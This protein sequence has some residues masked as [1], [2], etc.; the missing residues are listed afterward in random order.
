MKQHEKIGFILIF[1]FLFLNFTFSQSISPIYFQFVNSN[2]SSTVSFLQKIKILPEYQN[3]LEM[4]NNIYGDSVKGEIFAQENNKKGII[5]NLEQQLTINPKAR[6]VLYSLYQ[7]YL[8]EGD[9]NQA[10]N[11]LRQAKEVDPDLR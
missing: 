7:L 10:N 1:V 11:Y 8:E 2:K 9:K 6:D 5:N 3:I 4:N